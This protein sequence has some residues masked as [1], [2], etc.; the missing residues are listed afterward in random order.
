MLAKHSI[1][2]KVNNPKNVV[3]CTS[4]RFLKGPTGRVVSRKTLLNQVEK[5]CVAYRDGDCKDCESER[6]IPC[7]EAWKLT[8]GKGIKL[9]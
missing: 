5:H 8:V 6:E 4:E 2:C 1:V 3:V 9:Y 7:I